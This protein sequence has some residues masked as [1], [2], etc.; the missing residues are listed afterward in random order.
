MQMNQSP[1]NPNTV[2]KDGYEIMSDSA[3]CAS[4]TNALHK[5]RSLT[6]SSSEHLSLDTLLGSEAMIVKERENAELN[7]H[8][9]NRFFTTEQMS[10]LKEQCS[11]FFREDF[12]K[13]PNT[14]STLS[15]FEKLQLYFSPTVADDVKSQLIRSNTKYLAVVV[16]ANMGV[17]HGNV[18]RQKN[19]N[20]KCQCHD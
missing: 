6:A 12:I 5:Y 20:I 15:N 3:V 4:V 17:V 9:G 18:S 8:G 13:N 16:D 1:T 7:P 10:N 11:D 2:I 19:G 14:P